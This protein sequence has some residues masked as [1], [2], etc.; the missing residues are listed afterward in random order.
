MEKEEL[1][2]QALKELYRQTEEWIEKNDDY[3][4]MHGFFDEENG[5]FYLESIEKSDAP[6][7]VKIYFRIKHAGIVQA[8][9]PFIVDFK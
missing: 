6:D 4:R 7:F 3:C 8:V 5:C 1:L 2:V 9:Y